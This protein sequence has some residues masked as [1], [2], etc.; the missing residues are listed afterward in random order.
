MPTESVT[1]SWPAR[2]ATAASAANSLRYPLLAGRRLKERS[3]WPA[4]SH[5]LLRETIL[6]QTGTD[7]EQRASFL[8]TRQQIALDALIHEWHP[9]QPVNVRPSAKDYPAQ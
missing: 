4:E 8:R 7:A 6:L 5:H 3:D 2:A 9:S 1:W